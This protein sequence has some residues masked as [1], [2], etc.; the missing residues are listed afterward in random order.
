MENEAGTVPVTL[1]A[2]QDEVVLSV[3]PEADGAGGQAGAG[4]ALRVV[5]LPLAP[6]ARTRG[7]AVPAPNAPESQQPGARFTHSLSYCHPGS[8]TWTGDGGLI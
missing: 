7:S 6:L 8:Y 4:G 5:V 3:A 1:P 2:L